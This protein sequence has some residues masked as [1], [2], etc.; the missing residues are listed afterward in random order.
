MYINN[1]ILSQK[2]IKQWCNDVMMLNFAVICKD[3]PM[4]R[5][6]VR[7]ECRKVDRLERRKVDRLER[8]KA[9]PTET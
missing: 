3:P 4:S 2:H 5:P 7:L 6:G 1:K 9:T 8:R